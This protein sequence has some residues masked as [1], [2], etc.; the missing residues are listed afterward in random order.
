MKKKTAYINYDY[1]NTFDKSLETASDALIKQMLADRKIKSVYATKTIQAG[2]QFE[3]EVYPEFTKKEIKLFKL[4]KANN[5]AQRN[6]N[7]KN[8]RK[9]VERI[10]NNN[11]KK[12]D[13]W[14]TLTYDNQHL[15][16]NALMAYRNMQ[17]FIKRVNY[18]RKKRG[19]NKA[20]YIYVT[21]YCTNGEAIRCHHHLIMDC[22]LP[23]DIVEKL[24]TCGSRNNIRRVDPDE[25]ALT[26]LSRYLTKDP[27]GNKRWCASTNLKKPQERK[28]YSTFKSSHVKKI[29]KGDLSVKEFAEKIKEFAE[30]KYKNKIYLYEETRYNDFNGR[31]Y[32]Y[33]RMRDADTNDFK[34]KKE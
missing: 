23:M 30:K 22:G 8:A 33:I 12:G 9:K 13:Y 10:I 34:N 14:I 27:R 32:I 18:H 21:E 19:L 1:E 16:A 4:K 31:F 17:N 11:F 2:N 15:P 26:G 28:T 3:V 7:D 20:K 29:V 5:E 25:C 6:L 24:W